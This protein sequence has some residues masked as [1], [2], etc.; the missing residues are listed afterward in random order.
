VFTSPLPNDGCSL[1]ACV[2][3]GNVFAEDIYEDICKIAKGH[4]VYGG[5]DKASN[6]G[7]LIPE[8]FGDSE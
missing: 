1:V 8:I 2:C 7:N 4:V 5:V 3:C 6:K